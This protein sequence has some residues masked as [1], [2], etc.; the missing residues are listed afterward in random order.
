MEVEARWKQIVQSVPELDED[1][2][3]SMVRFLLHEEEAWLGERLKNRQDQSLVIDCLGYLATEKSLAFVLRSL[4]DREEALQLSAAAA[5]RWFPEEWILEPLM[6]MVLRQQP[7]A[8]KAGEVL[9]KKGERGRDCLWE[10]W[11]DSEGY[12]AIQA[13][14]LGFLA[15]VKEPRCEKLAFLALNSPFEELQKAGLKAAGLMKMQS[16]WGNVAGLLE[17]GDWSVRAKAARVLADL[18][19]QRALPLLKSLPVDSEPWVMESRS[20][21][22]EKLESC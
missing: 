9:A 14:I 16:L 19:D 7:S 12:P 1:Q 8:A 4:S 22:I 20:Q 13:Q 15:E 17:H 10:A 2:L 18:G 6:N 21:S 3:R 11:F 5:L